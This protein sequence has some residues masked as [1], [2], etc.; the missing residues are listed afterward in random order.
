MATWL[1]ETIAEFVA[2]AGGR[3]SAGT[4]RAYLDE[5][6]VGPGAIPRPW[7]YPASYVWACAAWPASAER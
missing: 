3:A 7:V 1:R 6:A 5:L 4:L 2:E